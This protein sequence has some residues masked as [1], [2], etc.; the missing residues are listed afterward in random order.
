MINMKAERQFVGFG[1][2]R[3][4]LVDGH[5]HTELCPHGSGDRTALM[6][7]KAIEL[8]IEKI[9]LTEHAPL[10]AGFLSEYGGNRKA[11]E[12]ASLKMNQVDAYLELGRQL[13]RAY[14]THID[15]S[16]GFEV[17]YIPGFETEIQD[18][19]D[20]YGPLTED[21]ILSVHFMDGVEGQFYCVD[22]SPEELQKGFA[23][24]IHNQ[25]EL[26]YKYFTIMRQAVRADLGEYTPKRIGHF[27]L[28][29][30]FQHYFGYD[31]HLDRRNAQ[32]VSDI[33]HIMH[34]Q[35]RELDYNM[36]GFFKPHCKEMYPSRF[37]QGMAAV[38]GVP[39]VLGSDAHSVADIVNVWE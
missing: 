26:Y 38:I 39:F 21:N 7:E 13:Q 25:S 1:T 27:D 14:G 8:R 33:L 28:I 11:Y 18:F 32:V 16:L 20:R 17:D 22:Y 19:L 15:I 24:W 34:V 23:P 5:V 10:P 9:C 3:N 4:R 29:K 6:I 30:K 2:Y 36:S 35:G 31:R 37:I 12:M